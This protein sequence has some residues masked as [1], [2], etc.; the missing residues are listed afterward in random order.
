MG[1]EMRNLILAACFV[2][3]VPAFGGELPVGWDVPP[4]ECSG[5]LYK[6]NGERMICQV[7][8]RLDLIVAQRQANYDALRVCESKL[9]SNASRAVM[10]VLVS[11]AVE[12]CRLQGKGFST[13]TADCDGVLPQPINERKER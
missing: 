13:I 1:V 3:A 11:G 2:I 4:A 7:V 6:F 10:S 5:E 12:A 9:I 8:N